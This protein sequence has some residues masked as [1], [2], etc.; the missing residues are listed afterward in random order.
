M[1]LYHA[2]SCRD[3]LGRRHEV[4]VGRS[5]R[6]GS[7]RVAGAVGSHPWAGDRAAGH[8]GPRAGHRSSPAVAEYDGGN[9][10][11]ED[12]NH[13]EVHDGR[14]S[15]LPWEEDH[16]RGHGNQANETGSA[17]EDGECPFEAVIC[18]CK[19]P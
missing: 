16:S 12:C 2:H 8:I 18:Q 6:Q 7:D 1:A 13:E 17:R 15:S 19:C 4:V 14:S 10:R 3:H 9:R 5:G 11:D